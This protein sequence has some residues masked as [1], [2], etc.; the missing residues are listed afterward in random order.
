M[1]TDGLLVLFFP[2]T[3]VAC[4][5]VLP[6]PGY[7]C[8]GC[9]ASVSELPT[10]RCARCAEPGAFEGQRCPRCTAQQPSFDGAFAPFEHEGALAT[11]IHRFKYGGHAEL[12]RALGQLMAQ[13]S[14]SA[15]TSM[16]GD[17]CPL[18]LHDGRYLERGYDQATLLAVEV[19]KILRRPLGDSFL[20][21][22]RATQRQ[23]GLSESDR[24][25]NVHGAFMATASVTGRSVVLV[26]DVLTT[27]ST[28]REAARVLKAAGA[29]KVF[30]LTLARARRESLHAG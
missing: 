29:T 14:A 16:P 12:S 25:T 10:S 15:L 23:V 20:T 27:G 22:V 13:R 4:D 21:R 24:D 1:S 30:V 6:S 3:C 26:D 5:E 19:A 11:A 17:I 9:S 7:F 28:A 2:P 8:E 18:P